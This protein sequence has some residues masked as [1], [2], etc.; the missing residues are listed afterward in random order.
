MIKTATYGKMYYVD[1][2]E[3]SEKLSVV[4]NIFNI[5]RSK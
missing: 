4:T 2:D 3:Y 1:F 5:E